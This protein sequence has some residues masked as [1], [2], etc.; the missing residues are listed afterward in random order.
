MKKKIII[1]GP[2]VGEF[3]Y[4]VSWWVPEARKLR[5]E[6]FK[7]SYSVHIGYMGREGLYKDFIDEYIAFPKFLQKTL[8]YPSMTCVVE[9]GKHIIPKNA[10]GYLNL[11]IDS[12]KRE[13]YEINYALPGPLEMPAIIPKK[14]FADYPFG[15]YRHLKPSPKFNK[16]VKN[17]LKD[18]NNKRSVV[19]MMASVRYRDGKLEP[20]NWHP[21]KYEEFAIKLIR[22]LGVNIVLA[23]PKG[24]GD[25]PGALSLANSELLKRYKENVID[26]VFDENI[27]EYQ[28]ALLKNT[29]CSFWNSTGA[30]TLAFFT[31]TPVFTQQVKENGWR[32]E[33]PWQKKLTG[34]HKFVKV[35]DKYKSGEII[36][37][38][39]NELFNEFKKFYSSLP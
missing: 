17:R 20:K 31:N 7:D 4:E 38:P 36:D 19:Y 29:K 15:E 18:F 14:A 32:H 12:F 25:Y 6:N 11:V 21:K 22:D 30:M 34:G 27:V 39:V 16:L 10:L 23:G 2:W 28:L 35:F 24:R 3:T 37:S 33:L 5:N 13:G 1:F 9:N 8:S 26:L